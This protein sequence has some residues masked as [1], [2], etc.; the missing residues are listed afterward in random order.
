MFCTGLHDTCSGNDEEEIE[1][2]LRT[3]KTQKGVYSQNMARLQKAAGPFMLAMISI[4]ELLVGHIKTMSCPNEPP[5]DPC[6]SRHKGRKTCSIPVGWR[7]GR[8]CRHQSPGQG[9]HRKSHAAVNLRSR[10]HNR[11]FTALGQGN[12]GLS[13]LPNQ[14]DS[15]QR[16]HL[17]KEGGGRCVEGKEMLRKF[18]SC[19]PPAFGSEARSWDTVPPFISLKKSWKSRP[20]LST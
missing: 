14:R 20:W 12:R 16:T 8:H 10:P 2:S 1:R 17:T 18:I 7:H 6:H 9:P 4:S 11:N 5:L 13:I 19:L 3:E 15:H